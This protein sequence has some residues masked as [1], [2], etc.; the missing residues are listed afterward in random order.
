MYSLV[1]ALLVSLLVAALTTPVCRRACLAAGLVDR[2]DRQRKLHTQPVPRVGGVAIAAGVVAAYL[3]LLV[4]PLKGGD[5]LATHL[6]LALRL[7]PAALVIFA[8]GLIDDL[9]TIGP[10]WKLAGQGIAAVSAWTGG[11]RISSFAGV[12]LEDAAS[13]LLTVLW[14]L[15][16]TNALNLIDG[17]DGLAAGLGLFA[18]V[19][20]LIAALLHGNMELALVTAP[21]AGALVGFLRYNFNPASIFLGDCGSL[22]IGFL[23]GCFAVLWSQKSAT[24]LGFAAPVMT[25]SVPILDTALAVARR[26]VR[27]K[28]IFGA[29]RG[30]IHHRLL[31]RGLPPRKAVLIL[32]ACAGVAAALSLMQSVLNHRFAGLT[33]VAFCGCAWFGIHKLGY[34]EFRT[35]GNLITRG[36]PRQV[37]ATVS[38]L[39]LQ[40]ALCAAEDPRSCW[41]VV[42]D[43]CQQFG[44]EDVRLSLGGVEYGE[45][46]SRDSE[47][48]W[49]VRIPLSSQNDYVQLNRAFQRT[50]PEV[51]ASLANTLR[52]ALEPKIKSLQSASD[53]KVV[54]W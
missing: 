23:L 43:A 29:D 46:P 2:P 44:Y 40:Q 45:R 49:T 18:A 6:G 26:F 48:R 4:L 19:T 39:N 50:E 25:L 1:I 33:I 53:P 16:C 13:C 8:T 34:V 47:T 21:L 54:N 12:A 20:T 51:L 7:A 35:F 37:D 31:D 30:H 36:I 41:A 10:W 24:L 9:V 11:V 15:V 22:L 38:L 42:R 28:P 52:S 3:T 27:G 5:L 32:Y 14:L 17:L